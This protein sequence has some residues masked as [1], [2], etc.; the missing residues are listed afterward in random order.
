MSITAYSVSRKKKKKAELVGRWEKAEKIRFM[1][2]FF[3]WKISLRVSH[4]P[5]NTE[6]SENQYFPLKSFELWEL[7]KL[8]NTHE[9]L[10][11]Y[12][13]LTMLN[14]VE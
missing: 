7:K 11:S 3:N 6:E 12:D 10:H 2:F 5:T 14:H 9:E 8:T 1:N 13:T 4:L